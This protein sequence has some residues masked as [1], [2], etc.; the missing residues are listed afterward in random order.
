MLIMGLFSRM[1]E[2]E[3]HCQAV[4][5]GEGWVSISLTLVYHNHCQI[6]ISELIKIR[7]RYLFLTGLLTLT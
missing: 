1:E 3:G 5:H 4:E 7:R 6:R 2:M